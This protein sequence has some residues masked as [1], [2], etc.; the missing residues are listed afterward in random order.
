MDATRHNEILKAISEKAKSIVPPGSDVILFGSQ[1][2][3]DAQPGSDWDVL[4]LLDKDRVTGDDIDNYSYPL[5]EMGWDYNE[6]IN[7]ILY[8]KKDWERNSYTPFYK[9]VTEDGIVL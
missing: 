2:R 6:S 1:A 7:A 4:I 3:G 5:C 8:T 9:N